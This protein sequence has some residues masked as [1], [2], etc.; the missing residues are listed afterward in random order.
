MQTIVNAFGLAAIIS[1]AAVAF[2]LM[3]ALLRF[4][5]FAIGTYVTIGAFATWAANIGLGLPLPVAAIAGMFAS[6]AIVAAIDLAVFRP[7]RDAAATT[8]LLASVALS[9]VLENV[10]RFF[11]GNQ[12]KGFNV[13]LNRPFD[14]GAVRIAPEQLLSIG[15]AAAALVALLI[16]LAVLPW[17]R[18]MRAAADD[19][20]LASVRGVNVARVRFHG[21]LLAGTLTG[22]SGTLAGIDL[23]VEPGLGWSLTVPVLAAAILGGIGSVTGAILGSLLVGLAEELSVLFLVP[24]YKAGVGFIIIALALLLRP[25]GLLGQAVVRK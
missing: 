5:N 8:L 1:P 25:Q 21:L 6:A 24:A 14:F 3:F 17:G 19:P 7:L 16:G 11:F 13:P 22:L 15:I 10:L 20:T 4:A 9:F 2:T 23:A 12:V 18:A